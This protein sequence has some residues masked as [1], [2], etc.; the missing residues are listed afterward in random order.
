MLVFLRDSR[1]E[2][3]EGF[4]IGGR[5]CPWW[6]IANANQPDCEKKKGCFS[7]LKYYRVWL[8]FPKLKQ[9]W[10]GTG[11]KKNIYRYIYI[12]LNVVRFWSPVCWWSF[13][14]CSKEIGRG[15]PGNSDTPVFAIPLQSPA[16]LAE[17]WHP[18]VETI[19]LE[20]KL[21]VAFIYPYLLIA[22]WVRFCLQ[23]TDYGGG[24]WY[25][26]THQS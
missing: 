18:V 1:S 8:K 19:A 22:V 10:E 23:F 20:K 9:K 7:Q 17:V 2:T 24:E 16:G 6:P 3:R 14:K 4:K 15:L 25:K 11:K 26:K 12:F 13:L 5:N 21:P